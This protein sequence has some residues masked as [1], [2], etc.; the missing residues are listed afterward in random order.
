MKT[1]FTPHGLIRKDNR[2]KISVSVPSASVTISTKATII[3][4]KLEAIKSSAKLPAANVL[5]TSI[6]PSLALR[7][8]SVPANI[9]TK[10]MMLP[11]KIVKTAPAKTLYQIGPARAA[12]STLIIRLYPPETQKA[13]WSHFTQPKAKSPVLVACLTELIGISKPSNRKSRN[14]GLKSLLKNS[15]LRNPN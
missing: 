15:R 3:L 9:P 5:T 10:I 2:V 4:H 1:D 8:S 12:R 11:K 7:I 6:Y 14:K 13:T